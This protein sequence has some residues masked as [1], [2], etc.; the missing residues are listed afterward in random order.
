MG[1]AL[2]G[3]T[4]RTFFGSRNSTPASLF[5]ENGDAMFG[6]N[7][8][9]NTNYF[10]RYA[11]ADTSHPAASLRVDSGNVA[12]AYRGDGTTLLYGNP[13]PNHRDGAWLWNGDSLQPVVTIGKTLVNGQPI[14]QIESG[15]LEAS[16]RV[17]LM[18]ATAGNPMVVIRLNPGEAPQALF[19]S[20]DRIGLQVPT[21]LNNFV[22][23][24]NGNWFCSGGANNPSVSDFATERGAGVSGQPGVG[25]ISLRFLEFA[26]TVRTA[27]GDC[28]QR[29]REWGSQF[30]DGQGIC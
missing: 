26:N 13:N 21:L 29:F 23:G 18:V 10:L 6:V 14:T 9:N 17:T 19:Q 22:T 7:L 12:L 24:R 16:G 4:V 25:R 27:N 1:D 11:G 30:K 20:G 3:T 8:N 5:A 15:A 28:T 2:L